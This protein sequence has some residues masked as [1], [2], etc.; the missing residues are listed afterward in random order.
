MKYIASR[1]QE[2]EVWIKKLPSGP[3]LKV[4]YADTAL[5]QRI[6]PQLRC[7]SPLPATAVY[8]VRAAYPLILA[9]Y[10]LLSNLVFFSSA[11]TKNT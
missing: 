8:N 4:P 6:L 10:P 9:N 5:T 7:L 3:N 11:A 2:N 1:N